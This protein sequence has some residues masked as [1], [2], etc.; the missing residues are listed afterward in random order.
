MCDI[1]ECR[2]EK[3]AEEMGLTALC[4]IPEDEAIAPEEFVERTEHTV[5]VVSKYLSQESLNIEMACFDLIKVRCEI[6]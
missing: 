6:F 5:S 3:A 2:I 1:I 4:N